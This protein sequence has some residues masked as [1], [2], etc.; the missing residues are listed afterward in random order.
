MNSEALMDKDDM[1]DN[2]PA[3]DM[4]GYGALLRKGREQLGLTQDEVAMELHLSRDLVFHLENESLAHLP[5]PTFVRGYIRAYAK[6]VQVDADAA[7]TSFNSVCGP[8]QPTNLT[9]NKQRTVIRQ[10]KTHEKPMRWVSY[11]IFIGI[12]VLVLIWWSSHSE[13]TGSKNETMAALAT[14]KPITDSGVSSAVSSNV[15]SSAPVAA[16]PSNA[17]PSQLTPTANQGLP[18]TQDTPAPVSNATAT[19]PP[20]TTDAAAAA[21]IAPTGT[22]THALM[23]NGGLTTSGSANVSSSST[24]TQTPLAPNK[25]AVQKTK[26]AASPWRNPDLQ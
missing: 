25:A 17:M 6:L 20:T 21:A 19:Q 2:I 23:T 11:M 10:M 22:A 5:G 15:T 13:S 16:M 8:A 7:I 14:L 9:P 26:P 12:V 4:A 1:P 3:A 24:E 18:S